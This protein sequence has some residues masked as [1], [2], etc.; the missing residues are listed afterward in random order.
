MSKSKSKAKNSSK[1]NKNKN[2]VSSTANLPLRQFARK[3]FRD[4][5]Q[6][7]NL[8]SFVPIYSFVSGIVAQSFR[9]TDD[10]DTARKVG[11]MLKELIQSQTLLVHRYPETCEPFD[12][13]DLR[14]PLLVTYEQHRDNIGKFEW[15]HMPIVEKS[16]YD[17]VIQV[18]NVQ[19]TGAEEMETHDQL[20][21]RLYELFQFVYGKVLLREQRS[22]LPASTKPSGTVR[23]RVLYV[24]GI[25]ADVTESNLRQLFERCGTVESIEWMLDMNSPFTTNHALVRFQHEEEAVKAKNTFHMRDTPLKVNGIDQRCRFLIEFAESHLA[26]GMTDLLQFAP[27]SKDVLVFA[28]KDFMAG[29]QGGFRYFLVNPDTHTVYSFTGFNEA[30]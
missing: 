4:H 11:T 8:S 15:R 7:W 20:L 6:D 17:F 1:E 14:L 18:W 13:N 29:Y 24:R 12:K 22:A 30:R 9:Y 3:T 26:S 25:R 19:C 23:S 5:D 27:E 16:W 2:Q 10:I 21:N 28:E